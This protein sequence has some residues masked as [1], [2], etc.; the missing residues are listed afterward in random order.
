MSDTFYIGYENTSNSLIGVGFDR[1]NIAASDF[2]YYNVLNSWIQ[3]DEL[4]GALMIR[5]VFQDGSEFV[6]S[7]P[8][9]ELTVDVYPNPT[10]G[11]INLPRY[12]HLSIYDLSGRFIEQ[13]GY[14]PQ[15]DLS[16]YPN[17]IYLLKFTI[18]GE[19][20]LKKVIVSH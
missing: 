15:L 10:S 20:I 4:Q 8:K 16:N 11:M 19:P 5:P 1:N 9:P 14:S 6:L 17:G 13:F 2:I 12:D 18:Q 7:A 3:N